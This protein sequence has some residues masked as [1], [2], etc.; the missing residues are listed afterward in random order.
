MK[1]YSISN[2]DLIIFL[3]VTFGLT[4][5]MGI[6]MMIAYP[7][8]SVG[9][10]PLLQMHYPA[11][12]VMVALILNKEVRA[13]LPMS[14]FGTYISFILVAITYLLV[15]L[16]VFGKEPGGFLDIWL[17]VG[18]VG[19]IFAYASDNEESIEEFGL[20]F[21]KDF[22]ISMPYIGLFILTYLG[23]LL[24]VSA[25]N[26]EVYAFIKPFLQIKT[27][28]LLLLL[29]ISF[30]IS[31]APFLGE[32]YGWRYFLQPALQE[33]LGKRWGVIVLGLIWGIWHLP[34]NLFYYSPETPLHSVLNQ[35]IICVAYSVFF[36]YVYM[37]TKNI[38]TISII[39]FLNNS[40][41][42]LLYGATGTDLVFTWKA[43]LFNLVFLFAI[44]LPFLGVKEYK[45]IPHLEEDIEF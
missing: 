19:L 3:L 35:L 2:K 31:F 36:G 26:R 15:K 42:V 39:H 25:I 32:E 10:F 37:R 43:L 8:Y 28:I 38:W 7:N 24:I 12:G 34:V 11:L 13:R 9:S 44:Y 14:F 45:N 16:F 18:S 4:F 33:R 5:L 40:L 21:S 1:K 22:K 29:P 17:M 41:G 23:G 27:W 20:K 6:A 30:I